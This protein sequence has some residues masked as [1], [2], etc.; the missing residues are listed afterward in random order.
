MTLHV[1]LWNTNLKMMVLVVNGREADSIRD[2]YSWATRLC[3]SS[4]GPWLIKRRLRADIGS[5]PWTLRD[6]HLRS[7]SSVCL[8]SASG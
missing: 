4:F 3:S 2:P 1:G 6:L 7:E 5:R 8:A